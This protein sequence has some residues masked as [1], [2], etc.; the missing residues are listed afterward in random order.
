MNWSI[1]LP[2]FTAVG[3]SILTGVPLLLKMIKAYK[4]HKIAKTE[5]EKEKATIDLITY[6]QA[7]IEKAE[8]DFKSFD[9]A[10]K[11]QGSSAGVIKKDNVLTK[12][13]AYSMTKGY[14]FDLDLW[15]AKIDELVKFTK[16]VN[17][18]N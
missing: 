12:L 7:L 5:A 17:A 15:S 16:E 3:S 4:M 2:M 11:N 18:K 1:I 9:R 14:E 8:E 13:Q 10:M 6:A